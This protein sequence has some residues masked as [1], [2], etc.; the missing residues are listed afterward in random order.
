MYPPIESDGLYVT[1]KL[2]K[3]TATFLSPQDMS[4]PFGGLP[5]AAQISTASSSDVGYISE[6]VASYFAQFVSVVN[7]GIE[8]DRSLMAEKKVELKTVVRNAQDLLWSTGLLANAATMGGWT[9]PNPATMPPADAKSYWFTDGGYT[10]GPAVANA[11]ARYQQTHGTSQP[12]K[13]I[14]CNHNYWTNNN[15]NVLGYF[16]FS[17]NQGKSPGDFIWPMG[18]GEGPQYNPQMMKQIFKEEMSAEMLN[19]LFESVKGTNLTMAVLPV[20]TTID[21][22]SFGVQAGQSVSI[23]IINLNSNITTFVITELVIKAET[24][25]LV[26]LAETIA[27]SQDLMDR[28]AA[29]V[30]IS[31]SKSGKRGKPSGSTPGK[32][33]FDG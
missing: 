14:I 33:V 17:G 30:G 5:T 20:A 3:D 9:K 6:E 31:G 26:S 19:A 2:D 16:N 12:F 7:F 22:E 1:P 13:L 32:N 8:S 28:V 11:I 4:P 10:D 23:A 25:G 21:N 29:F 27:S 24:P 15:N 18:V